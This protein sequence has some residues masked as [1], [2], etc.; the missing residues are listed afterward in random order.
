MTCPTVWGGV[1]PGIV[2]GAGVP[3]VTAK[4][5]LML[6]AFFAAC[7]YF[8]SS[9]NP[10]DS[11]KTFNSWSHSA[12][13]RSLNPWGSFPSMGTSVLTVGFPKGKVHLD[14]KLQQ[15]PERHSLVVK[16]SSSAAKKRW[17]ETNRGE[18]TFCQPATPCIDRRRAPSRCRKLCHFSVE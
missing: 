2:W 1:T 5:K 17:F 11:S 3:D 8:H 7:F 10:L 9:D 12:H 6:C 16:E 13:C 18:S 15:R 4:A 14:R